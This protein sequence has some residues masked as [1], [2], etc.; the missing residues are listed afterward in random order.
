MHTNLSGLPVAR[1]DL[2]ANYD[3]ILV[4]GFGG[5]ERR[6]DVLPFLENVT[7]AGTFPENDSWKWRSTTIIS[8]E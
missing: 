8:T 3:A 4:V 2:A 5:P 1:I 7:R 6:E